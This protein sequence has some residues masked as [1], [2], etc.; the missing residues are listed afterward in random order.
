MYELLLICESNA[1]SCCAVIHT[2]RLKSLKF[3]QSVLASLSLR[4]IALSLFPLLVKW[5]EILCS[6]LEVSLL[7]LAL[8]LLIS[9]IVRAM[10]LLG[11]LVN[12]LLELQFLDVCGVQSNTTSAKGTCFGS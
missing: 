8:L 12:L 5:T 11:Q 2:L 7:C 3:F 6:V 10:V 4:S 1:P 9:Q